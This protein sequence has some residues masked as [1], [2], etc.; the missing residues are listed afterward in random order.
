MR[1]VLGVWLAWLYALE[2]Y[3]GMHY[4]YVIIII[5]YNIIITTSQQ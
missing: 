4:E 2:T 5:N 3:D 1:L